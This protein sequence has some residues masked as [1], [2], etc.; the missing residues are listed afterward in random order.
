MV[1][2]GAHFRRKHTETKKGKHLILAK[3]K[4]EF[5]QHENKNR[6]E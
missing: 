6:I 2:S 1:V 3:I 5:H 4:Y